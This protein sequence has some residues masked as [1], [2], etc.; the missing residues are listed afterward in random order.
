MENASSD[1]IS[2]IRSVYE[3]GI[4]RTQELKSAG[5]FSSAQAIKGELLEW[6][7][8]DIEEHEIYSFEFL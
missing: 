3:W 5:D 7:R 2:T 4:K 1:L 6:N 8:E